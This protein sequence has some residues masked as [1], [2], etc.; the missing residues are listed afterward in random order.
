MDAPES[1]KVACVFVDV[2]HSLFDS[3]RIGSFFTG[4]Q[5]P[6]PGSTTTGKLRSAV[7]RICHFTTIDV[8]RGMRRMLPTLAEK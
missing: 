7:I 6:Y 8:L 5:V 2:K 1:S 4:S 3:R